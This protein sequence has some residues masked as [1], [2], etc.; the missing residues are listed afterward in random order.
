[1]GLVGRHEI[2]GSPLPYYDYQNSSGIPSA[3]ILEALAKKSKFSEA[4]RDTHLLI[5]KALSVTMAI[6]HGKGRG[7]VWNC[8]ALVGWW[9]LERH[10]LQRDYRPLLLHSSCGD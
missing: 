8:K 4:F 1:M 7:D 3:R 5:A 10:P 6:K 2:S 9:F